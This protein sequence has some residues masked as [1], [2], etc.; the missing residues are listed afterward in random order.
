MRDAYM[1]TIG[2]LHAFVSCARS[3]STTRAADELHLTQSAVSR[4]LGTLEER[5]GVLLFHRVKQRLVL[6]DAGHAFHREAE[7][8]LTDLNQ[9]AVAV[10]AFGGQSEVLRLA[11]L[12][13]F[14]SRWL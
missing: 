5:L 13:T 8:I 10:M 9:A 7:R 11:V 4:S 3:G 1:P 12:P 6:S 14:A 2:E